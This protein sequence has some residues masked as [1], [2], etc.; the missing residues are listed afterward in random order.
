MMLGNG[1]KADMDKLP[2]VQGDDDLQVYASDNL[3]K[4][5]RHAQKISTDMGDDFVSTEH[6]LLAL[7]EAKDAT[8]ELLRAFGVSSDS[9]MS[10]L[11]DIRGNQRVTDQNPEG[12]YQAVEK[13]GR[14]LNKLARK[15]KLDPVIGRDDEIRRTIQILSRRTT[16]TPVLIGEPGVG[17][18][19]IV[20]GLAKRLVDGD[21][22]DSLK[23]KR[24]VAM[25]IAAII[26]GA[27][28]PGSPTAG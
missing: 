17:K 3:T 4:A 21:V 19:A 24:I 22:P 20:E 25:D 18:T 10:V 27:T 5:L 9:I 14:D 26:A 11:N 28:Y 23:A 13:Y 2:K 16:N 15:G 7:S 8:G 12:K 6:V 1:L